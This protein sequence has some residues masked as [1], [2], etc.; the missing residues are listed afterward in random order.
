MKTLFAAAQVQCRAGGRGVEGAVCDVHRPVCGVRAGA[1]RRRPR[2]RPREAAVPR[3]QR[4]RLSH[5][6]STPPQQLIQ[7]KENAMQQSQTGARCQ[8]WTRPAT[9]HDSVLTTA[10]CTILACGPSCLLDTQIATGSGWGPPLMAPHV[11]TCWQRRQPSCHAEASLREIQIATAAGKQVAPDD[12][13]SPTA[14]ASDVASRRSSFASSTGGV[15][16]AAAASGDAGVDAPHLCVSATA[17]VAAGR[18]WPK[19][20]GPQF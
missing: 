3:Q 13:T 16:A 15:L 12:M 6:C 2:L 7:N 18:I 8:P 14:S 11:Y 19:I 1:A 20:R 10:S 9:R 5:R 4:Q 17:T